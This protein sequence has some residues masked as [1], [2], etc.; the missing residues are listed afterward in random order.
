MLYEQA[1][2]IALQF[3]SKFNSCKEYKL[4]FY[5]YDKNEPDCVGGNSDLVVLKENGETL[6]TT[7]FILDYKPAT[8]P[9]EIDF[10]TGK[11]K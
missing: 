11:Y 3:N 6:S 1:K 5:F 4:A 7:T 2:E 10:V 9:K 8:N